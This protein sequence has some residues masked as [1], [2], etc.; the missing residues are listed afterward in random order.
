MQLIYPLCKF[1]NIKIYLKYKINQMINDTNI[2]YYIF[3]TFAHN[4]IPLMHGIYLLIY[5]AIKF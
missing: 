4:G 2:H 3:V 5:D 1:S